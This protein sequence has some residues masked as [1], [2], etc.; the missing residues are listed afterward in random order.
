[1]TLALTRTIIVAV[2]VTVGV[3]VLRWKHLKE[4]DIIS[5]EPLG[6]L[7]YEPFELPSTDEKVA[8][9]PTHARL[10]SSLRLAVRTPSAPCVCCSCPTRSAGV[11]RRGGG[12][13][14]RVQRD[15]R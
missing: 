8:P 14:G 15:A 7:R 4:E 12:R 11:G 6:K 10:S 5:L 3:T 1:M 13:K 2:T 9:K